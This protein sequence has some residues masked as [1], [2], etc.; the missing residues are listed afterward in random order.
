MGDA[1]VML[2]IYAAVHSLVVIPADLLFYIP[3]VYFFLYLFAYSYLA[4]GTV[5]CCDMVYL[6]LLCAGMLVS[7]LLY[8]SVPTHPQFGWRRRHVY[9]SIGRLS[10]FCCDIFL[11]STCSTRSMIGQHN[12]FYMAPYLQTSAVFL[13][14]SHTYFCRIR[15]VL[16]CGR[17]ILWQPLSGRVGDVGGGRVRTRVSPPAE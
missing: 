7:L 17:Y 16:Q 15:M 12:L 10:S 11:R 1:D 14:L 4:I 13:H 8:M 9:E 3:L 5:C 6:L 2:C